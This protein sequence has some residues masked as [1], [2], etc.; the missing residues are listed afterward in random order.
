[1]RIAINGG[2]KIAVKCPLC[3]SNDTIP[4]FYGFPPHDSI[5]P[6]LKAADRGEIELGGCV[7]LDKRPSHH[8][9]NCGHYFGS[10]QQSDL[11]QIGSFSL[12]RGDA[13]IA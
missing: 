5:E 3:R 6:F 8:C 4:I 7:L 9:K 11:S 12:K 1:L 2:L 10:I 13:F